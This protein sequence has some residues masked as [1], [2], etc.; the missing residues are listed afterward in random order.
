ME[1]QVTTLK[2]D[3]EAM[4]KKIRE[5][6]VYIGSQKAECKTKFNAEK[7]KLEEENRRLQANAK[8]T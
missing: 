5:Q 3:K 1:E 2:N 4:V 8:A 7:R 6:T